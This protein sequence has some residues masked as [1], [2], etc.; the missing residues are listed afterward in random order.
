MLGVS[1]F[2]NYDSWE[3]LKNGSSFIA[4]CEASYDGVEVAEGRQGSPH[5]WPTLVGEEVDLYEGRVEQRVHWL[6]LSC[7]RDE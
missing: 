1:A 2:A 3:V 6:L 7:F 4:S 5:S